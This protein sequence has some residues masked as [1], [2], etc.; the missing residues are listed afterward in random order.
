MR[1]PEKPPPID[2]PDAGIEPGDPPEQLE[3]QGCAVDTNKLYDL[4]TTTE[5][6]RPMQLAVDLINSTFAFA[7]IGESE[8]CE[9]AVFMSE[10][11]GA[12]GVGKPELTLVSDECTSVEHVSIAHNGEQWLLAM[13]DARMGAFDLWTQTYGPDGAGTAQR[14][15]E[16][17]GEERETA[18]IGFSCDPDVLVCDD[19]VKRALVAWV[20]QG[21]D[22]TSRLAVRPLDPDG[23]PIGDAVVL[24]EGMEYRFTDL[25]L[26][27]LGGRFVGLAYR[28]AN[29]MTGKAEIVLD[30]LEQETGMR[31]RDPWVL[32]EEAGGAGGVDLATDGT[33]GGVLY[34]L[35]Q[36]NSQ[37]LWF[38]ALDKNGRAAP[39]MSGMFVGGPSSPTRVVGPPLA[40]TDASMAKLISGF[41]LA[42]R[43]R[44]GGA[45]TEPRI[46]VHFIDA[47]G[48]NIG[49]SDVALTAEIGGRS[50][51]EAA[52]DGRI[53]LGWSST[54]EE[55]TTTVT[56]A[57]LPCVGGL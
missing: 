9:D 28:R 24:E 21:Q 3:G 39:V 23:T 46:R 55:G 20:E 47:S 42:Y 17:V 16:S 40:A 12:S 57:K 52:Y 22:G 36:A 29:P 38:Q 43:L 10:L 34:S 14:I 19:F 35:G 37:Q 7:F 33:G 56:A 50:A 6:P 13:S 31:N 8:Q 18:I 25:S 48:R 44:P 27:Q 1:G 4:T 26:G 5:A 53:T 49:T 45:V 54:D 11:S 15:T 32:T 41:A 30:V 2:R 51:I